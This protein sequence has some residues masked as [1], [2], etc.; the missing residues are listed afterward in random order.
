MVNLYS[1]LHNMFN[2]IKE[3]DEMNAQTGIVFKNSNKE[4][5]MDAVPFGDII[6]L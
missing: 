2:N 3:K 4:K 5:K 1:L 6:T